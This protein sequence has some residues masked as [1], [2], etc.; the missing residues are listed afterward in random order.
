MNRT[1][2]PNEKL[3]SVVRDIFQREEGRAHL[4]TVKIVRMELEA[5]FVVK[6][7][8]QATVS[9]LCDVLLTDLIRHVCLEVE[10][11]SSTSFSCLQTPSHNSSLPLYSSFFPC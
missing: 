11:A 2:P 8:G 9:P 3:E 6:L 4:L 7:D 5:H 1:L 10:Y